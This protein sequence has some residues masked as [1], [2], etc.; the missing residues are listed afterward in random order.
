MIPVHPVKVCG[1][2]AG[3]FNKFVTRIRVMRVRVIFLY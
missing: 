2:L 3:Y 1:L